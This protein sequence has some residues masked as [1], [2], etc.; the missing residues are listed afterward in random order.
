MP[1]LDDGFMQMVSAGF[2]SLPVRAAPGSAK[3]PLVE[4]E[5]RTDA[6]EKL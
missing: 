3:L 2:A 6:L 1:E 4:A 5:G